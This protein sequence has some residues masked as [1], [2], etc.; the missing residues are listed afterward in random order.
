[1]Q[2]YAQVQKRRQVHRETLN[3]LGQL[4]LSRFYFN[5]CPHQRAERI[6]YYDRGIELLNMI[7]D[8]L[9]YLGEIGF[10]SL[11]AEVDEMDGLIYLFFIEE[12]KTAADT[13]AF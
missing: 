13:A 10:H 7:Y 8:A 1:V 12:S 11:L 4:H 5:G 9:Q 3:E 6:D 2:S